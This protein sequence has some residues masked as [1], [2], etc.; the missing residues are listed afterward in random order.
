MSRFKCRSIILISALAFLLIRFGAAQTGDNIDRS[1][2]VEDLVSLSPQA[3][4]T[5]LQREPGLLLEFKKIL[6]RKAYEQGRLLDSSDLNDETVFQLLREDNTV[7]ALAT[8][9]IEARMYVLA[10]PL[11]DELR[12]TDNW[13]IVEQTLLAPTSAAA[14]AGA[15]PANSSQEAQYW[16]THERVPV[17]PPRDLNRGDD[18]DEPASQRVVAPAQPVLPDYR[19]QQN[20]AWQSPGPQNFTDF[21]PPAGNALPHVSPSELPGLLNTSAAQPNSGGINS[22]MTSGM[23]LQPAGPSIPSDVFSNLQ[24]SGPNQNVASTSSRTN[25]FEVRS[26]FQPP[27]RNLAAPDRE[28]LAIHRRPDPYQ[29]VPSLYDLYQQ[30]AKRSPTPERFGMDI[31]QNGTGN[32]DEL[33]MDVP[34]GP[35]YVVGPGD[36]LN[37]DIWGSA[38]G[39]LQRIV[40]RQGLLTLPEA[41]SVQVSG[42]NLAEVQHVV[43]AALR[44]QYHSAQADV[45]LARLRTVRIYVVGDVLRP[46]AYDVSALSTPLNALYLAGGPTARGSLRTL[47]HYRGSELVENLDV[48][49]LL[50]HGV[51]KG[52]E[53][54]APGD[55]IQVPPLGPEVT[56]EGMVRRPA[57]YELNGE[58]RLAEVLEMAGGVLSS[59][60]LR[61]IE[62][63]RVI[64]HE[65]RTLLRLD[66]PED[67]TQQQGE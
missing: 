32:M 37:I 9:E 25:G 19:R 56:V 41:G 28:R 51:R 22:Q 50:L 20:L 12:P 44:S 66:L 49:D 42:K 40:D 64:A 39:R 18:E 10:K 4:I 13:R 55:T 23:N 16:A 26:G 2:E 1:H 35:E 21:S 5:I 14:I 53:Q 29:D 27:P 17:V 30:F 33:P 46:G 62:V 61:H 34:V 31:F 54:L 48:Y 60:T 38:S 67:N 8:R 6:V 63:E 24:T 11:P 47:R 45:S 52:G 7:R 65:N 58:S 15:Q 57:I 59:G 36:G 3:V 43:Q